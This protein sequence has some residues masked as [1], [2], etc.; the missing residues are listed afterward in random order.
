MNM[1][2]IYKCNRLLDN[3]FK[4][5]FARNTPESQGALSAFLS[6]VTERDLAVLAIAANEPPIDNLRDRQIRFDINCR[7]AEGELINVEMSLS[8]DACEP[9]RLEFHAGK[10]FTGQDIRGADKSYADLKEAYQI[11]VLGRGNF[12]G[13]EEFLH[14]FEYYDRVRRITLGGRSRIITLELSKLEVVVEKPTG[15]MN[16]AEH[17]G[18]FFRYLTDKG[19]RGKINEVVESEEGIA[20]ASE[21]LLKI[22]RNEEERARLM[23]EWKYVVDT[24]SK[25]VQARREGQK[26]EQKEIARNL[27]ADGVPA[28]QIA[29]W[30]GLPEAQIKEL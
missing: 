6:A 28:E 14:Q 11:A 16:A 12:F 27:K 1:Q 4:A 15:V 8:P 23:S 18:V 10:L 22:S 13:D 2:K 5:V 24:Q 21:V 19:R 29:K 25:V 30:T 17:W 7:A 9:V 26:E 3:V 20:M